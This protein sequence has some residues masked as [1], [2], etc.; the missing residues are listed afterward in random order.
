MPENNTENQLLTQLC[1]GRETAWRKLFDD[2]YSMLCGVAVEYVGDDFLAETIV[3]DVMYHLWMVRHD[4]HVRTTLEGYLRQSVRNTCRNFLQSQRV[5]LERPSEATDLTDSAIARSL[6]ADSDP[7][8]LLL[9]DELRERVDEAVAALPD[10]CKRVFHMSRKE[11]KS[12]AEIA[13]DLG[14]SVNTVKYHIRHALTL[15]RQRLGP[16]LSVLAAFAI[17]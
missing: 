2:Y 1:E 9:D 15:L 14:I 11:G 16:Y 12:N 13:S 5:R 3:G 7:L 6:G 10:D 17:I 4:L 8:C